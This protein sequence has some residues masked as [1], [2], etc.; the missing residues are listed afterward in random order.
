MLCDICF[1]LESI[2][3]QNL[4]W[5]IAVMSFTNMEGKIE[6]EIYQIVFHL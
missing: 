2:Q 1:E 6:K 3:K 4:L 5:G